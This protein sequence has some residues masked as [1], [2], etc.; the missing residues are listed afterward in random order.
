[1]L[2][3]GQGQKLRRKGNVLGRVSEYFKRSSHRSSSFCSLAKSIA[4]HEEFVRSSIKRITAAYSVDVPKFLDYKRQRLF[5]VPHASEQEHHL[6][7]ETSVI[8]N[9]VR[10]EKL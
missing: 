10:L 2:R 5:I 7:N 4:W 3:R 6:W 9:L 8:A 1:M